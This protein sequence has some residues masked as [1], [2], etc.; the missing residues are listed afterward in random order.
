MG[1][2]K[3]HRWVIEALVP[4][5]LQMNEDGE[6]GARPLVGGDLL[7]AYIPKRLWC[8]DCERPPEVV[9]GQYCE[10]EYDL[11]LPKEMWNG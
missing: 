6:L 4:T 7:E 3:P 2:T 8:Y 5:D 9:F 1:G 10:A 11:T